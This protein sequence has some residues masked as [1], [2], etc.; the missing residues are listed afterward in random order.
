ME[1]RLSR[2]WIGG[3]V[4]IVLGV[5]F[6]LG[7][8]VPSF[9]LY[10]PLLVGLALLGF[11]LFTRHYGFLIPGCIVTGVGVGTLLEAGGGAGNDGALFLLSLA[12]G[13]LAIWVLGLLF[14][15]PGNP[16]WPL[17]P[18]TV[19]GLVGVAVLGSG[20]AQTVLQLLGDWWPLIPIVIGASILYRQFVARRRP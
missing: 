20:V 10:V 6:L 8:F 12:G 1:N 7:R 11:F 9:S 13:F 16:V 5:L 15:M 14:R 18:A 2:E 4:L 19:L 3:A 17:I